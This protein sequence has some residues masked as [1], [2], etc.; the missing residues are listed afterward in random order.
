MAKYT[1]VIEFY[2]LP[3]CGKTTLCERLKEQCERDGYTAGV[4]TDVTKIGTLPCLLRAFSLKDLCW[5]TKWCI[6]IKMDNHSSFKIAIAPY[7]RLLI[8]RCAKLFSNYDY[9]FIEH[10]VVQSMVSA[11]YGTIDYH[12]VLEKSFSIRLLENTQADLFVNCHVEVQEAFK[13]IRI[14]NR[15]TSGRFDQMPDSKLMTILDEQMGEF[16]FLSKQLDEIGHHVEWIDNGLSLESSLE[17]C[18]KLISI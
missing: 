10:G 13:R 7:K 5:L 6:S 16:G 4:L 15:T 12:F 17:N 2:G 14:R 11:L 8:Y 9:V 18:R 1:K 3:G